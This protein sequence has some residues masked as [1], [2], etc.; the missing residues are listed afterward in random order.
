MTAINVIVQRDAV[1]MMTD[2]SVYVTDGTLLETDMCKADVLFNG[3]AALA[4]TG[5]SLLGDHISEHLDREFASFN[6]L[7]ERGES[8]IEELFRDYVREWRAN[9]AISTLYLIGWHDSQ[10]RPAAYGMDMSTGG[11]KE[12]GVLKNQPHIGDV[13]KF[14]IFEVP[15]GATPPPSMD[16]YAAASYDLSTNLHEVNAEIDLLHQMEIQ[17]RIAYDGLHYVGGNAL[18]TSID[19]TGITQRVVHTWPEDKVGEVIQPLPIDYKQWLAEKKFGGLSRLQRE[20][21]VKKAAKGTLR[22]A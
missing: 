21:M 10:D 5:P 14:K 18:M 8:R 19:R 1:H 13:E 15:C 20:R 9:D 17:R 22:A 7:V 12:A 4:C 16:H 2:G 11:A 3:R 6:D